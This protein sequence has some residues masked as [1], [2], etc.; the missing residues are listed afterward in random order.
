MLCQILVRKWFDPGRLL[1]NLLSASGDFQTNPFHLFEVTVDNFVQTS[2][3][4]VSHDVI[5]LA[6]KANMRLTGAFW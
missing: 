3:V 1:E 5:G 6:S 4:F 2:K